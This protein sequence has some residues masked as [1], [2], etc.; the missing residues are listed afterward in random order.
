MLRDDVL[1]TGSDVIY[2]QDIPKSLRRRRFYWHIRVMYAVPE[3]T[4]V[5]LR[6]AS[7]DVPDTDCGLFTVGPSASE[8][9]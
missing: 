5:V 9:E 6:T 8:G 4:A 3:A 1:A 7:G 2:T